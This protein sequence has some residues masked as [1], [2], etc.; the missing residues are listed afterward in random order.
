MKALLV[1]L[2]N[3]TTAAQEDEYNDWYDNVHLDEVKQIPGI[4]DANRYVV[5]DTQLDPPSSPW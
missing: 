5:S 4:T 3:P 2:S 1:V